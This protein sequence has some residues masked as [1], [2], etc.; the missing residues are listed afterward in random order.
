MR[1]VDDADA[2][3]WLCDGAP[4]ASVGPCDDG[5][6][7]LPAQ[8]PRASVYRPPAQLMAPHPGAGGFLS[9]IC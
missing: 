4:P 9:A 1:G 7:A 3:E 5:F 8:P 6:V 2:F